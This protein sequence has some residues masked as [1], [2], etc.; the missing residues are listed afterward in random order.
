MAAILILYSFSACTYVCM[1]RVHDGSMRI[2]CY[3]IIRKKRSKQRNI[4]KLKRK[5]RTGWNRGLHG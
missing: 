5:K 3:D 4:N 1:I 2:N